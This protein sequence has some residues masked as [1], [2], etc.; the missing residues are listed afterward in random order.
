MTPDQ[1]KAAR[2]L[3]GW[4]VPRLSALSDTSLYAVRTFE[5]TG[6]VVPLNG[7]GRAKPSD[8]VAAI[9]ATLEA[10]GVEFTN[11]QVPGVRLRKSDQ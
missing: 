10:A 3:L 2:K 4:S 11:G 6:R 8:P 1:A 7:K 9:R 5:Q